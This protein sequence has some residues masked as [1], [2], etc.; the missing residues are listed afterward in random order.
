MKRSK[1]IKLL[2]LVLCVVLLLASCEEEPTSPSDGDKP[3]NEQTVT[4]EFEN[5]FDVNFRSDVLSLN[6]AVRFDGEVVDFYSNLGVS[7]MLLKEARIDE[8][9]RV[10]EIFKVYNVEIGEI[11]SPINNTY[12]RVGVIP[13]NIV[14]TNEN[15]K[16]TVAIDFIEVD[17]VVPMI[18]VRITEL[19]K[20]D[21]DEKKENDEIVGDYRT[22]SDVFFYYDIYGTEILSCSTELEA[23]DPVAT[24]YSKSIC[25]DIGKTSAVFDKENLNLIETFNNET[26][27][28]F[29]DYSYINDNYYY[30]KSSTM[31]GGYCTVYDK[32]GNIVYSMTENDRFE[33]FVLDNG[34]IVCQVF[35]VVL[36]EENK[37]DVE[38]GELWYNVHTYLVDIAGNKEVEI[39]T[40]LIIK[41][42]LTSVDLENY[43]IPVTEHTKNLLIYAEIEKKH[44]SDEESGFAVIDNEFNIVFDTENRYPIET[45][46]VLFTNIADGYFQLKLFTAADYAIIDSNGE[47]ASLINNDVTV[48][49]NIIVTDNGIY[50]YYLKSIYDFESC[51]EE[52]V[53]VVGNSIIVVNAPDPEQDEYVRSYK[54]LN[55]DSNGNVTT[56][57]VFNHNYRFSYVEGDVIVMEDVEKNKFTAFNNKCEHLFTTHTYLKVI[58]NGDNYIAMTSADGKVRAYALG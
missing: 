39:K 51:G 33:I 10:C 35:E 53:T 5:Y 57:S 7:L 32:S 12:D 43:N 41:D 13:E 55:V 22:L 3:N 21:D 46:P 14:S 58:E 38:I 48:L 29:A 11:L 47:T 19:E 37:G 28:V 40:N 20:I 26:E 9:N 25:I 17:G 36:G 23:R 24:T 4:P 45:T 15:Q 18:E 8:M 6:E 49:E 56:Q 50:D 1:I 54:M 34:N 42:I 52:L 44:V 16:R 30:Y 27:M 2:S 31:Y